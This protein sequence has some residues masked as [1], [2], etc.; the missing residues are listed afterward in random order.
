[1]KH[2][3]NRIAAAAQATAGVEGYVFDSVN[4]SQIAFWTCC[5]TAPPAQHMHDFDEYLLVVGGRYTLVIEG[6]R[7]VLQAGQGY[8][9]RRGVPHSGEVLAGTGTIHALGGHRADRF[10]TS[11]CEGPG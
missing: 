4:G 1:M 7:I 11:S 9:I 10:R 2:P 5:E 8:A 6:G 3:A